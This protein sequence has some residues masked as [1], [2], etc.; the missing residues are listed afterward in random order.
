MHLKR[1]KAPKSWP[2]YRKGTKY[3]VRP[4][5]DV[6][7]GIPILIVLRDLLKVA[8]NRKEVKKIIHSRNILINNKRVLDEKNSVL[9]FDTITLV[10]QKK[11]Y[12]LKLSKK[13][14]FEVQEIKDN[15]KNT[16]I[17]K[18]VNKRILKGKKV[19]LNLSDGRNLLSQIQCKVN[20]SVLINP[21]EKKIEKCLPLKEKVKVV[22]FAGKRSGEEGI[23]RKIDLG[24]KIAELDID[25]KN[26][27]VLIKQLMVTE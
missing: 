2:I 11:N 12:R 25:K 1:Q 15:E 26:V 6:R 23:I 8:Q 3:I 5:F 27:N 21:K 20:D 18:I 17:A 13:G 22:V 24:R 4:T 19:Q 14:K 10:P 16:K 7:K 9:L